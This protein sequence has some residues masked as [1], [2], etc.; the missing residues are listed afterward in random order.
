VPQWKLGL[1][2]LAAEDSRLGEGRLLAELSVAEAAGWV[3]ELVPEGAAAEEGEGAGVR[4]G[5]GAHKVHA[6]AEALLAAELGRRGFS[7]PWAAPPAGAA[8]AA[9]DASDAQAGPTWQLPATPP[10]A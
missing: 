4:A 8:A 1:R 6:A 3:V 7:L 10:P 9:A 2:V 5:G